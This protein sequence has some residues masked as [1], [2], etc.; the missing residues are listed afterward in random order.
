[1]TLLTIAQGAA[2][3][4]GMSV[5]D[6]V[7]ASPDREWQELV[8]VA[9]ETG[10]ELARRVQ[11]GDLTRTEALTGPGPMPDDFDRLVDGVCVM[12]AGIVR[13]LTRAEWTGLPTVPSGEPRYF[14]LENDA[15]SLWPEGPVSVTYQSRNWT[16]AGMHVFTADNQSPVFDE[17]LFLKGVISRWRRFKGMPYADFEADYEAALAQYAAQDD[18]GRF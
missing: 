4:V 1:M 7:F 18:R 13:P 10:A 3:N 16:S 8:Q 12:G 9:N 6:V 2:L 17:D 15:I 14:L 5:P 11:W